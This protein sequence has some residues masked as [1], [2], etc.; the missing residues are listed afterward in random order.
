[1]FCFFNKRVTWEPEDVNVNG[2]LSSLVADKV[3]ITRRTFLKHVN[4]TELGDLEASLRYEDH[5][6]IGLTMAGDP[7]VKYFRSKHHGE[8]VYGFDHNAI[9]Y[10]FKKK[11]VTL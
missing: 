9:E 4:R 8:T 3:F 11:R 2:G 7:Q 5:H 6:S 1:M 10:V